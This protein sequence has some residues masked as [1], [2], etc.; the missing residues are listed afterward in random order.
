[1]QLRGNPDKIEKIMQK[2]TKY[3]EIHDQFISK[4]EAAWT[5]GLMY[6]FQARALPPYS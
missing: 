3:Y 5:M 6:T 1:M 2:L 4:I